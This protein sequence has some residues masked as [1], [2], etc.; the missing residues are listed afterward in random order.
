MNVQSEEDPRAGASGAVTNPP[1]QKQAAV[2]REK[3]AVTSDEEE[4]NCSD[5]DV[6]I[7]E[8]QSGVENIELEAR[9]RPRELEK[10]KSTSKKRK[11]SR[12]HSQICK[13]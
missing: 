4:H 9:G 11:R 1:F 6:T 12:S 5:S 3:H 8:I 2:Y 13:M 7:G 10:D